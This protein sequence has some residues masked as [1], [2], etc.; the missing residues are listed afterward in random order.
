MAYLTQYLASTW[1]GLT[2]EEFA[3]ER[4]LVAVEVPRAGRACP[5]TAVY[6]VCTAVLV[7]YYIYG[8]PIRILITLFVCVSSHSSSI[9]P[10]VRV[11]ARSVTELYISIYTQQQKSESSTTTD[12][13]IARAVGARS[14][15]E[16]H[17]SIYTQ[18][19]Q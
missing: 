11:G 6:L 8:L 3:R 7:L 2:Y 14:V 17:I 1:H 16:L 12:G 18:Q 13:S 4:E 15:T 19:Q 10:A 9:A 5:R